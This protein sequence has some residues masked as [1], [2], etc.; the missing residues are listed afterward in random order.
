VDGAVYGLLGLL[1]AF[2]FSGAASRFEER[3]KLIGEEANAVGTAYLRLDLLPAEAQGPLKEKFRQYLD[4]RLASYRHLPD[5]VA[6]RAELD[7]SI[8]LQGEIWR[9]AVAALQLPGAPA[10]VA[11][12]PPINDMIDITTTRLVRMQ[13]HPPPIIFVLLGAITLVAGLLAGHGMSGG[14]GRNLLHMLV[15]A[16]VM[17]GA[18]YVIMDLEYPRGGLIRIDAADQTLVDVRNGMK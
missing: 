14:K 17:A 11:V 10:P 13:T 1:V 7:R 16:T 9:D 12:L 3:R 6:A 2:T 8:A 18:V 5:V 4:S 15:Y